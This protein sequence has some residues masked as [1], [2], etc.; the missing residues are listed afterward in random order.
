MTI[1]IV[2]TVIGCKVGKVQ[3]YKYYLSHSDVFRETIATKCENNKFS[4]DEYYKFIISNLTDDGDYESTP[5]GN[6]DI[7][8]NI[9]AYSI[10]E[11]TRFPHPKTGLNAFRITH[12][13]DEAE[14][15]VVG[16]QVL[17]VLIRDIYGVSDNDEKY[18]ISLGDFMRKISG[19]EE[20]LTSAGLTDSR[21][22][23]LH[24]DCACCS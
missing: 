12:D 10:C 18:E 14:G 1:T 4:F 5:E 17:K 23:T 19:A 15:F 20:K 13:L 9:F 24:D 21:I 11:I 8:M 7:M 3:L 16:V 22:F 2:Y 6:E